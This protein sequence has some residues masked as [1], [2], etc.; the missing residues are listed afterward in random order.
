MGIANQMWLVDLDAIR[1]IWAS[2]DEALLARLDAPE[3]PYTARL[4]RIGRT[5]LARTERRGA[6]KD[7]LSGAACDEWPRHAYQYALEAICHELRTPLDPE[8]AVYPRSLRRLDALFEREGVDEL[9]RFTPV[10]VEWFLPIPDSEDYPFVG[11]VESSAASAFL[12]ELTSLRARLPALLEAHP[13]SE[14][15][16]G[17]HGSALEQLERVYQGA[18]ASGLDVVIFQH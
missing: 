17:G 10:G 3:H 18:V 2:R 4:L 16:R 8:N 11:W 12:D 14:A 6:V 15:A 13:D 9:E 7:I 5:G 1:G